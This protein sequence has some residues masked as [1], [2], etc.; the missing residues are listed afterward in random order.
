MTVTAPTGSEG[1]FNRLANLSKSLSLLWPVNPATNDAAM[2]AHNALSDILDSERNDGRPSQAGEEPVSEQRLYGAPLLPP[3]A[4]AASCSSQAIA[5]AQNHVVGLPI[6][7][8]RW[9]R[10]L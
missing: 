9:L 6:K 10:L 1:L 3:P 5:G 7:A 2:T 4:C 8:S